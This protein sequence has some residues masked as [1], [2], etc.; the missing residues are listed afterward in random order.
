MKS[1]KLRSPTVHRSTGRKI[2]NTHKYF[3]GVWIVE[4]SYQILKTVK[5]R[6]KKI[7]TIYKHR[8]L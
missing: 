8:I 3:Y 5:T 2:V 6:D 7:K 1:E 4:E